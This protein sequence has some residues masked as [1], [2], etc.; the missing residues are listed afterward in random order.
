MLIVVDDLYLT[1][2]KS[3]VQMRTEF[4]HI[5]ATAQLEAANRRREKEAQEGARPGEP[6]T[7]VQDV[8]KA[9][10][11][12]AAEITQSFMKA[13]NEEI[14]KRLDYHDENVWLRFPPA[15]SRKLMR[16]SLRELSKLSS[17]AVSWKTLPRH[18][19]SIPI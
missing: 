14:W 2:L 16:R 17:N 5:D 8:K 3:L 6:K 15:F 11:D 13:T 19:Y 9:G 7:F 1:K 18:R 12:T 4:H 10:G